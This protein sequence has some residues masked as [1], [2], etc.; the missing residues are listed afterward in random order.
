MRFFAVLI[1]LETQRELNIPVRI[2]KFPL[3]RRENV[4][5]SIVRSRITTVIYAGC[6][7]N[8]RYLEYL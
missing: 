7:N 5:R 3:A 2:V 6:S 1:I 4:R 8:Y